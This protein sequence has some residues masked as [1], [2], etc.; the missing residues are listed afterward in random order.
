MT[1]SQWYST[2][3]ARPL[4]HRKLE[5]KDEDGNISTGWFDSA[6]FYFDN[7]GTGKAAVL[8]RYREYGAIQ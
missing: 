8:W 4:P 1:E 6:V 7:G 2:E 3:T 5:I